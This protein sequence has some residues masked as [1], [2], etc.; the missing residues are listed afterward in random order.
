MGFCLSHMARSEGAV[1]TRGGFGE[2]GWRQSEAVGGGADEL[3]GNVASAA[4]A[5]HVV[6]CLG[7]GGHVELLDGEE[8]C[9]HGLSG[10]CWVV[11]VRA[12][13]SSHPGLR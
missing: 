6:E 9:F 7:D 2:L 1:E 10:F 11:V 8:C 5:A 12:G 3:G 13:R 4:G